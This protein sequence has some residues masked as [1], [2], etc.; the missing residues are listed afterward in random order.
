MDLFLQFK[1]SCHFY[2]CLFYNGALLGKVLFGLWLNFF[3]ELEAKLTDAAVLYTHG[4][5]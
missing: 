1:V 5:G 3:A 2:R 4:F